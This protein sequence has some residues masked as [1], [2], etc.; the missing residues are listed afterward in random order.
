MKRVHLSVEDYKKITNFENTK[1][2]LKDIK[3][4]LPETPDVKKFWK[5]STK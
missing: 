1:T 4:E 3:L 5:T 2:V